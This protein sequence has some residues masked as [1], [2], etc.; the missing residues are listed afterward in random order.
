MRHKSYKAFSFGRH[1]PQCREPRPNSCHFEVTYGCAL[2]CEHC[3]CACYNT[4]ASRKRELS[5][6]Q[7]FVIL[8]KLRERGILWLTFSGGDPL[9]RPD[10]PKI[11]EYAK[12][13]GFLI[14][15]L[16]SARPLSPAFAKILKEQPPFRVEATLNAATPALH[17]R[18]SGVKG[19][20]P[21]IKRNLRLLKRCRVPL[22]LKTQVTKSNQGEL[23]KLKKLAA[24]L[25]IPLQVC[26]ELNAGLEHDSSPC[27]LRIA[28]GQYG[29]LC[30]GPRLR[31]KTGARLVKPKTPFFCGALSGQGI[32]VDAFGNLFVCEL[33]RGPKLNLLRMGVAAAQARALAH[34]RGIRFG[35]QSACRGC[36]AFGACGW[37]P[38]QAYLETGSPCAPLPYYCRALE[39]VK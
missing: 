25:K 17:D 26:Y 18:I 36:R 10:F 16:T 13:C 33:L 9:C 27:S 5:A 38:G 21:V 2:A 11:Y 14:T 29:R 30:A 15:I 4:A 8:D 6:A 24:G 23:P 39:A 7:V 20:L 37:C 22:L 1:F 34:L 3:H 28:A 35:K 19:A 12:Q 32:N 31:E